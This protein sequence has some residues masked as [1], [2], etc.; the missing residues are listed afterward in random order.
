MEIT[1]VRIKLMEDPQDRLRAFCSITLD[2]CFVVRDLKIIQG[3]KGSFVAMPSRKLTDRCSRCHCKNHLRSRN[4]NHCGQSLDEERATRHADGRAKL[5]ADIA[6]PINS[7]CR[8]LIQNSVLEA[9]EKE[10]VLAAEPGYVCSYDDFGEEN[11][12]DYDYSEMEMQESTPAATSANRDSSLPNTTPIDDH[13]RIEAGAT[14]P[15]APH[16][17][18]RTGTNGSPVRETVSART[19]PVDTDTRA[20]TELPH[21]QDDVASHSASNPANEHDDAF[22]AGLV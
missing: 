16:H 18:G 13:R 15:A 10:L 7:R 11:F 4:C 12:S 14:G 22:G 17:A 5:Y 21:P 9:Y 2:A 1:E 19:S 3:T 6:H 20:S 8:E